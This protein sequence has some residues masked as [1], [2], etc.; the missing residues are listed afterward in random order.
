[1]RIY[2]IY[3]S[4]TQTKRINR[5]IRADAAEMTTNIKAETAETIAG[6]KSESEARASSYADSVTEIEA[7]YRAQA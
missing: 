4:F 5:I 6:V 3:C 7:K 1:M 2:T